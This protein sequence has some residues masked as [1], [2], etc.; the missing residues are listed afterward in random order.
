MQQYPPRM[1]KHLRREG[2]VE[3]YV[4]PYPPKVPLKEFI[5]QILFNKGEVKNPETLEK[6]TSGACMK[7][8]EKA[9]VHP[10]V[11]QNENYEDLEMLGDTTVNKAIVWS[12][13]ERFPE[14]KTPMGFK[15]LARMKITYISKETFQ[16]I[17][18]KKLGFE[19]YLKVPRSMMEEGQ[20][21]KAFTDVFE[22]FIAATEMIFDANFKIG[23]GYAVA[24]N[25]VKNVFSDLKVSL[26]YEDLYDSITQLKELVEFK[27]F[28]NVLGPVRYDYIRPQREGELF[29]ANV[30]ITRGALSGVIGVGTGKSQGAAQRRA[31]AEALKT[32]AKNGFKRLPPEPW[33]SMKLY[34]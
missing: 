5:K 3:L 34:G 17:G 2:P 21:F 20:R 29:T 27:E 24:Y 13:Y 26:R 4:P 12:F 33:L 23:V 25:I 28:K 32:L 10:E 8:Y 18:E 1:Q 30:S 9:F 6:V 15:I 19:P 22:A 31:A 11:D 7:L 16:F 14:L